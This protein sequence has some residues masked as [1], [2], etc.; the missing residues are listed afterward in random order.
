LKQ[1][2]AAGEH[3]CTRA[4][5]SDA[6]LA[7]LMKEGYVIAR[8]AKLD[9]MLLI[10]QTR[11]PHSETNVPMHDCPSRLAQKPR[12][13]SARMQTDLNPALGRLSKGGFVLNK[14]TILQSGTWS[15]SH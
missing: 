13:E 14:T 1:L 2:K 6:G 7:R 12:S 10:T 4:H 8:T 15:V 9:L 5:N 11:W 3:G